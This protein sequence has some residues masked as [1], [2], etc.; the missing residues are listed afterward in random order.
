MLGRLAHPEPP[1]SLIM[2]NSVSSRTLAEIADHL[3]S[4]Q[5]LYRTAY[6]AD[7]SRVRVQHGDSALAQ[8]LQ[9]ID[10][11]NAQR[12]QGDEREHAV[13]RLLQRWQP[14]DRRFR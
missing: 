10:Q 12:G 7:L 3:A 1:R 11:R 6:D 14:Q 13:D 8:A 2:A 5:R 4:K 9:L